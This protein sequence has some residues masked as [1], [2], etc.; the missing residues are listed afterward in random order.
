MVPTTRTVRTL[1]P[2]SLHSS[3][4]SAHPIHS[5]PCLLH[6]PVAPAVSL[7]SAAM[8]QQE[9]GEKTGTESWK[10]GL[11][12]APCASRSVCLSVLPGWPLHPC[13]LLPGKETYSCCPASGPWMPRSERPPPRVLLLTSD[14]NPGVNSASYGDP[15]GNCVA[16]DA[17]R[18]CALG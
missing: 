3:P 8:A 4:I 5:Q 18:L 14:L 10:R 12:S 15:P 11:L 2:S 16:P 1:H 6:G 17:T 7:A 9:H 13:L